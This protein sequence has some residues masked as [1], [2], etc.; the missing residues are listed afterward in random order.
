M[1]FLKLFSIKILIL[2]DNHLGGE[3]F[4]NRMVSH[5]VE[6]FKR[7]NNKDLSQDKRAVRRLRSA[8]ERAKVCLNVFFLRFDKVI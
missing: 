7:K 8:C 1:E 5:F 6:E 3:D 2:G 4:D